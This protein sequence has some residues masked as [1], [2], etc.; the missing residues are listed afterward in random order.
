MSSRLWLALPRFLW[1]GKWFWGAWLLIFL[2]PQTRHE[3]RLHFLGSRW[4]P[5]LYDQPWQQFWSAGEEERVPSLTPLERAVWRAHRQD[6]TE[7]F[8]VW[9]Y[10]AFDPDKSAPGRLLHRFPR[11]SWLWALAMRGVNQQSNQLNIA[12]ARRGMK[13]DP[14][15]ALYPLIIAEA[16]GSLNRTAEREAMLQRAAACSYF[17]DGSADLRRVLL[18]SASK[19]GVSTW[20]E[21]SELF[22]KTSGSKYDAQS[23]TLDQLATQLVSASLKD[24]ANNRVKAALARSRAMMRVALLLQSAPCQSI[25]WRLGQGWARTAWNIGVP[26]SAKGSIV[27]GLASTARLSDFEPFARRY[28]DQA[29]IALARRCEARMRIVDAALGPETDLGNQTSTTLVAPRS[30]WGFFWSQAASASGLGVLFFAGYLLGWWWL[31]SAFNW[32]AIGRAS[33]SLARAASGTGVV[34]LSLLGFMAIALWFYNLS[35]VPAVA[36][37]SFP[38][39]QA[40]VMGALSGLLF[41]APPLLLALWCA[42]R[43]RWQSR[44]LLRLPA[45]QQIEMRLSPLESWVLAHA[46]GAFFAAFLALSLGLAG[47][48]AF[49][50]WHGLIGY[51]WLR[52]IAPGVSTRVVDPVFTSLEQPALPIYSALCLFPL[53]FVWLATWRFVVGQDRRA[54]FHSGIR[55]WKES[56]ASALTA[57]VWV[58]FALLL[59]CHFSGEIFKARLEI[60]ATRG[61]SALVPGLQTRPASKFTR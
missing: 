40:E 39:G 9:S 23:R 60:V 53:L 30:F 1:R 36:R 12:G 59:G 13:L 29:D 44:A 47:T 21:W 52:A 22:S 18:S 45:R 8:R 2:L 57:T 4:V 33:T 61:E 5:R 56:L 19:A 14:R 41:F 10:G 49:L 58:Y 51:D 3:A 42:A 6:S 46:T 26:S 25:Q 54:V 7:L 37:V 50:R 55:A 20:S 27:F 43:A 28:N 38:S 48:W 17:D 35:Q 11:E 16:M 31:A 34:A 24:K 15:N 32:R